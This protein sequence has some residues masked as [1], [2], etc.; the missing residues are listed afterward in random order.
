[1]TPFSVTGPQWLWDT[2]DSTERPKP[3]WQ[4][5]MFWCHICARTLSAT[6]ITLLWSM[7]HEPN[8]VTQILCYGHY[9][10]YIWESQKVDN[11]LFSLP[12]TGSYFRSDN[13]LWHKTV[14]TPLSWTTNKPLSKFEHHCWNMFH[15]V[16]GKIPLA[17]ICARPTKTVG[18]I[19]GKYL[20]YHNP[21]SKFV[22]LF[23]P[24][25]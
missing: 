8:Y 20:S 2:P 25:L 24:L 1:M 11:Q 9:A 17:W 23:I 16:L 12:L 13:A 19:L 7:S 21:F 14:T 3:L 15:V 22:D 18:K 4:F 5:Q 10:N 6:I